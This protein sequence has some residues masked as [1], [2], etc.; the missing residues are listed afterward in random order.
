DQYYVKAA[1]VRQK[2]IDQFRQVFEEYDVIASPSM[3]NVA[4]RIGE[5]DE[6]SPTEV[7]AMDTLTVGPN[8]AGLPMVS[9]PSGESGGMPTGLHLVGD[10]FEEKTVL[11]A[12]HTYQR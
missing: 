9:V 10:H 7:Y 1:E 12:A 3:P 6:L 2:I 5:A 11:D 4:P 8:L